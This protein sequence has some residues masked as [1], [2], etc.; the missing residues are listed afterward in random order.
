MVNRVQTQTLPGLGTPL[1]LVQLLRPLTHP[2]IAGAPPAVGSGPIGSTPVP[3]SVWLHCTANDHVCRPILGDKCFRDRIPAAGHG[4]GHAC[5]RRVRVAY[6]ACLR[7][8]RLVSRPFKF[9]PM[10]HASAWADFS[11]HADDM[12]APLV[13]EHHI[14]AFHGT[15]VVGEGHGKCSC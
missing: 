7:Q 3:S 11:A 14:R 10:T 6:Y 2:P 5:A 8:T 1:R 4:H 9:A 15:R 12:Q 13:I